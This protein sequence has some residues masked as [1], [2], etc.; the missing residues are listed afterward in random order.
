MIIFIRRIFLFSLSFL[1]YNINVHFPPKEIQNNIYIYIYLYIES[2]LA[3]LT[4]SELTI[5]VYDS[6]YFSRYTIIHVV[7]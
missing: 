2:E 6:R 1:V 3:G 7:K 5:H 4:L